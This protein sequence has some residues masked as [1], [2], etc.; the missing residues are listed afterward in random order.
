MYGVDPEDYETE[1]DYME[2][3]REAEEEANLW[4]VNCPPNDYGI[5]PADY[6]AEED[7]L[8]AIERAEAGW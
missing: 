6:D 1:D 7:Y 5:D 3:V 8:E 2:A 4:R